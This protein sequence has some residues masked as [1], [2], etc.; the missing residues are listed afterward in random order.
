MRSANLLESKDV[1]QG[2]QISTP[3]DPPCRGVIYNNI[4]TMDEVWQPSVA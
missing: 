4:Y 3:A 1:A 2:R